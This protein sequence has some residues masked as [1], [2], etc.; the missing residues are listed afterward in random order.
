[1]GGEV[2]TRRVGLTECG[3][4]AERIGVDGAIRVVAAGQHAMINRRQLLAVGISSRAIDGRLSRGEWRSMHRGVYL[5]GPVIPP[6]GEEMAA[7]LTCHGPVWIGHASAAFLHKLP[8]YPAKPL[9]V[10]LIVTGAAIR[11]PGLRVHRVSSLEP[12]EVTEVEGIPVTTPTRA[13]LDIAGSVPALLERAV[14][15]GIASR[16]TSR[17]RLLGICQ[18][19]RHAHGVARLRKL[20]DDPTLV[21]RSRHE[22]AF[23]RLLRAADLPQPHSNSL[24]G[25]WEVDFLWP[26][27]KLVV[28]VDAISS[29]TSP[30]HF[31]RDRR[32]DQELTLLGYT[33]IR[34]TARQLE[35]E[36]RRLVA[37]IARAIDLLSSPPLTR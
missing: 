1:M 3:L 2:S 8:P 35:E 24:I 18:G 36:P 27:I 5:T 9:P 7:I 25:K 32:K 6:L 11:R 22:R 14:S 15:E 21:T 37:R 4:L 23:R 28:E 12:H 19:R 33:V 26:A 30:F 10:S 29:H 16:K 17:N 34:V 20:L 13:I 31:E